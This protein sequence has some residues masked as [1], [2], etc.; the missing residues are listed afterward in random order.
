MLRVGIDFGTSN[1]SAAVYDGHGLRLLDLDADAPDP[2][3]MKSLVY[4][5][6]S[7]SLHFGRAALDTYLVQ[8]TGRAVKYEMR[9][10][11]EVSMTF[12]DVGTLVKD[13]FALIDVNE[14]GR[15][16]QSLKRFLSVVHFR[17]TNV[18]GRDYT[19]EELLSLLARH[20]LERIDEALG[21]ARFQ[22]TVG[23]P[24]SFSTDPEADTVARR[25]AREAWRLAG[26]PDV[27]FVE[28]PVGAIRHYAHTNGRAEGRVLVF[29]FGGGT[30]DVCVAALQGGAVRV[31]ATH[32]VSLGGDLLDSR[33]VQE[34]LTPLFGE[35]AHY[36]STG[37][38]L[39]RNLFTSLRTWQSIVELSKPRPF[40]IIRR[41]RL[42]TDQPAQLAAFE[43]L[44]EKN[45]GLALF[46]AVE[47]AKI[48]LSEAPS[49]DVHLATDA[50]AIEHTVGRPTFEAIVR[51]QVQ[52]ARDCVTEALGLA[53]LDAGQIDLVLTTG[54]SSSVPAFRR[55]LA[56]TLPNAELQAADAFT[57][58][59]AGL[60]LPGK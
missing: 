46:Q 45:Y 31:L 47:A 33:L 12:A 53:G 36:R 29:D 52:F 2:R 16:F 26:I 51:P 42:D 18:F 25:R 32:G 40:E 9:R 37:L 28:E 21:Y 30:L 59:A 17:A 14:P 60:A 50:F 54:G 27:E 6:R 24:V 13:A 43:A 48:E 57:S 15:L 3:V 11:G 49:A 1:S 56:G 38:P 58:V 8:N 35:Y 7:G 22:L 44:V 39:P 41:A 19:V 34:E 5:E 4:F 20:I 10:I 55:M 23:W